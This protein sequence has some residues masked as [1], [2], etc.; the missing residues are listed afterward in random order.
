MG[1]EFSEELFYC[2]RVDESF[3]GPYFSK[4]VTPSAVSGPNF[5]QSVAG[6]IAFLVVVLLA[7]AACIL[8]MLYYYLKAMHGGDSRPA[9]DER[10]LETK[11]ADADQAA[12]AHAVQ[13]ASGAA[14]QGTQ[15]GARS[16]LL[17]THLPSLQPARQQGSPRLGPRA[18]SVHRSLS[19]VGKPSNFGAVISA[20]E[21]E[22][23]QGGA[24]LSPGGRGQGPKA[25]H[26]GP[27]AVYAHRVTRRYRWLL[28]ILLGILVIINFYIIMRA[29][30]DLGS[31]FTVTTTL[32]AYRVWI[33][34]KFYV[35]RYKL[36]PANEVLL[37]ASGAW[38][39][40]APTTLPAP[41]RGYLDTGLTFL[42]PR[43]Q[44]NNMLLTFYAGSPAFNVTWLF[45]ENYVR[46]LLA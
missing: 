37:D 14:T 3:G 34:S 42:S 9:A 13:P 1:E 23:K 31:Y 17:P 11:G 6:G 24:G 43:V 41:T 38:Y 28:L 20:E 2:G 15:N 44:R 22:K 8:A 26:D 4:P 5:N 10:E 45:P 16:L 27:S 7:F 35:A 39:A 33:G 19:V 29:L 21:E 36:G 30:I 46:F 25:G 40:D 32:Y 12:A 18:S